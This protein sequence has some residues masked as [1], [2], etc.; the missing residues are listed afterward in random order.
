M[1]ALGEGSQDTALMIYNMAQLLRQTINTQ[2]VSTVGK[3]LNYI[4]MYLELFQMRY[5]DMI[6]Y[7]VDLPEPLAPLGI[8]SNLVQPVV[9]NCIVHGFSPAIDQYAI[10]IDLTRKGEDLLIRIRDNG[11][12]MPS[13]AVTALNQDLSAASRKNVMHSIGL[14]NVNERI[15]LFYGQEYGVH[16]ESREGCSTTVTLRLKSFTVE[17]VSNRVQS[18]NRR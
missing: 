9:E 16:I 3:E 15:K 18:F 14:P 8:L 7:R 2:D 10:T 11:K 12:G 5:P 17:E 4:R 1:R 13:G 6:A